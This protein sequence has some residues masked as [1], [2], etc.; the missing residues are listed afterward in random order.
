MTR[1]A[2]TGG[3]GRLAPL[4]A[5]DLKAHGAEVVL[6]SRTEDEGFEKIER[7]TS[8]LN[9]SDFDAILH[10]GWSTVPFTSE[11]NPGQESANDLPLLKAMVDACGDADRTPHF[12]FFS[13]GAV[14]GN[15]PVTVTEEADCHPLGSYAAAKLR[16]E[17]KLDPAFCCALR[18]SNIFG[19]ATLAE[20][21]QG[22]ITRLCASVHDGTP[23]TIWGDGSGT[24]DYLHYRDF[25][26]AV[27]AVLA[28][29]LTG[30]FNVASGQS[31]SL[32]EIIDL[33][34]AT[35]GKKLSLTH[36]RHF[37]WDVEHTHLSSE[38]LFAA[39][40]WRARRDARE[41]IVRMVREAMP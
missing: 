19:A 4:L 41:E 40:G 6:F 34:E 17:T 14:Y 15:T 30:V 27:R 23:L 32:R 7:L 12:L 39:T 38:K 11:Q 29:R 33:V 28:A 26:E 16:A 2:I 18:V 31:L 37:G 20:K 5:A 24:K 1:L 10:L 36:L 25:A 8:P 9:V 3:R 35:A 21:P 13:T 22:V